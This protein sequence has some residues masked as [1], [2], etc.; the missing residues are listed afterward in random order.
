[1]IT[2][3]KTKVFLKERLSTNVNWANKA[4]VKIFEYQTADEQQT[5]YTQ[6][7]NSV[8]FSGVDAKILT[9][10]SK[11]YLKN[12]FLTKKQQEIVL[13]KMPKYWKQI[14]E[15]SDKDKLLT[16]IK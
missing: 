15:I 11:F 12:G 1:M 10:L 3:Q 9:G 8:G 13:K 4:L 7:V 16:L 2:K 5:E 6:Y 14:L